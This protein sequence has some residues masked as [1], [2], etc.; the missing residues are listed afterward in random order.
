[1]KIRSGFV[2]NSSSSSFCI[3]GV[4]VTSEQYDKVNS[5]RYSNRTSDTLD[6]HCGISDDS[7]YYIGYYPGKMKDDETLSQFKDRMIA[8]FTD[9]GIT[10]DKKDIDWIT[11][12]GY[13][14]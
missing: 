6:A 11:D 8:A 2:S 3:L 4:S 9:V 12:G 1:M 5:V 14:G 7:S 10:V 13:N